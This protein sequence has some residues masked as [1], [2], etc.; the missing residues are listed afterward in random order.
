MNNDEKAI[1]ADANDRSAK[2]ARTET[3]FNVAYV[4][5]RL[6]ASRLD[7]QNL[8]NQGN[9]VIVFESANAIGVL[10]AAF[11]KRYRITAAG[12]GFEIRDGGAAD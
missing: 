8:K 6:E 12:N 10:K 2:G 9:G 3:V 7:V 4:R 5:G 1:G 11:P